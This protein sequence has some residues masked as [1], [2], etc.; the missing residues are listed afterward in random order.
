[1]LNRPFRT[2]GEFGYAFRTS[3]NPTAT[4]AS[5]RTIDFANATSTDAPILDLFTYNSASLRAGTVNLNT[6]NIAVIA[7][8][9][10]SAIT[11]ESTS[12][13]V[14][15]AASNNAAASPIPSPTMGVVMDPVN[16][17]MMRPAT[18]RQDIARLVAATGNTIGST[19]EAKETVARALSEVSQTRT[20]VLMID[21]IA[22][23]GRYPP[24][25]RT[26]SNFVVEGERRYWL[27]IAVDRFTGEVIDRQIEAVYE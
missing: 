21:L 3:A 2:A 16:G 1:M 15:L 27:H 6:Q 10:R 26:L 12:A 11:N 4:P 5:P 7:A 9:L 8:I 14:G 13:V 25:A 20:W 19:E 24:N 18:G 17:T 22:Q 23:S